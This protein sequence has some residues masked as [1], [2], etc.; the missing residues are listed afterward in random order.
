MQNRDFFLSL[1]LSLMQPEIGLHPEY[2]ETHLA[3]DFCEFG[4]S[5]KVF[6]KST[7]QEALRRPDADSASPRPELSDFRI[8][9]LADTI[10]LVTY[11]IPPSDGRSATLRSS[12]WRRG[13]DGWRMV[14]HQGTPC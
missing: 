4:S 2:A 6:D 11:R 10:V 13:N 8:Q 9:N 14:F 1:E 7:A 3:E 12:L 5:G